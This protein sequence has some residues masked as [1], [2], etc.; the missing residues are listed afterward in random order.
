MPM[1]EVVYDREKLY[2]EVW[3]DPLVKVAKCYGVS[4][5]AL[6]KT[7]KKLG[8]PV[9]SRGYWTRLAAGQEPLK[10]ALGQSNGPQQLVTRIWQEPET[11]LVER[12][13][14]LGEIQSHLPALEP[15]RISTSQDKLHPLSETARKGLLKAKTKNNPWVRS[16][17]GALDISVSD[18]SLERAVLLFDTLLKACGQRGYPVSINEHGRHSDTILQIMGERVRVALSEKATRID[19]VATSDEV[20]RQSSEPW[21]SPPK[22]DY[23]PSGKLVL[24]IKERYGAIIRHSISDTNRQHLETRVDDFITLLQKTAATWIAQHR[25]RERQAMDA[26]ERK[27]RLAEIEAV[28]NAERRRVAG[29]LADVRNWRKAGHIREFVEAARVASQ[30]PGNSLIS[31]YAS[32]EWIKWALEQADRYDPLRASPPSPIDEE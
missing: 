15:I 20:K 22:W 14:V 23:L 4:D 18:S 9:P 25:E 3:K 24:T 17:P 1:R 31:D 21:Y 2:Q 30:Q 11:L 29:L 16:G 5:V 6:A 26:E 13:R 12:A 10:P 8:V 32:P 28:R 27:L 7:C 19:H